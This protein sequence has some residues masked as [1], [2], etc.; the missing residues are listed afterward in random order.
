MSSLDA[1]KL[2]AKDAY[3]G[4]MIS[5]QLESQSSNLAEYAVFAAAPTIEYACT[6]PGSAA[7]ASKVCFDTF[8][9]KGGAAAEAVVSDFGQTS[10]LKIAMGWGPESAYVANLGESGFYVHASDDAHDV[11]PVTNAATHSACKRSKESIAKQ[12][13]EKEERARAAS[14]QIRQTDRPRNDAA[15]GAAAGGGDGKHKVA[16]LMSDGDNLQWMFNNFAT[17]TTHWWG[18][19]DR[20]KVKLG[21]TLSPAL[22]E[23][24]PVI[25]EYLRRTKTDNDDF[26]GAPS[27]VGYIYPS[28]WPADKIAEFGTLTDLYMNKT[29]AAA[30]HVVNTVNVIGDPCVGG[31]YIPGCKGLV[32]PNMSSLEPLLAQPSVDG[33]FWYTFGAGYA[34]WSDTMWSP[35]TKKPVVGARYSLWGEAKAG[36]MLGVKPL[37][38]NMEK[39]LLERKIGIDPTQKNG[40]SL[41]SVHAWSHNVTDVLQ[42]ATAL[43]ATGKFEVVTP[44]TLMASVIQHVAPE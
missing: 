22:V 8:G 1:Y 12:Q 32:S 3:S 19:P 37:I 5:F 21:F 20:G 40:Y 31:T 29:S 14:N 24:G 39:Q 33:V 10:G 44:S 4:K 36:T 25:L 23:V 2:R 43:E 18:S 38:F 28:V 27:G 34:G 15:A 26:V 6:N 9:Y 7:N 13:K 42:V 17:D 16:F 11:T 41:I 35:T 30:D